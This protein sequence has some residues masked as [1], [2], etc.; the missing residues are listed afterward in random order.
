MKYS[1]NN[2]ETADKTKGAAIGNILAIVNCIGLLGQVNDFSDW[3]SKVHHLELNKELFEGY[4][5]TFDVLFGRLFDEI[6]RNSSL[7]LKED[8]WLSRALFAGIPISKVPNTS[9]KTVLLRNIHYLA[10]NVLLAR[11]WEDL[12]RCVSVFREKVLSHFGGLSEIAVASS[13][14]LVKNVEEAL[15]CAAIF[16]TYIF[17]ND[18]RRGRPH[19]LPL[20]WYDKETPLFWESRREGQVYFKRMFKGYKYALQ[21]IWYRLLEDDYNGSVLVSLSEAQNW[22]ELDQFFDK[23]RESVITPLETKTKAQFGFDSMLLIHLPV[24]DILGGLI[25]SGPPEKRLTK[26]DSIDRFF[27]WYE[28]ELIDASDY[29]FNG[30]ASFVP[31]LIGSIQMRQELKSNDKINVIRLV[32]PPKDTSDRHDFSYGI[33][34]SVGSTTGLSDYSG[35]LLFYDCCSDKGSTSPGYEFV[36]RWLN[37]YIK[38]GS[39]DVQQIIVGKKQFLK[40]MKH[41][42]IS[43][44]KQEMFRLERLTKSKNG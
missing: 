16:E 41:R 9:E 21:F 24:K 27:F 23:I 26:K 22:T 37:R 14:Y 44:T 35:W 29:G 8:M 18:T 13:T 40:L 1:N 12:I 25:Q 28:I 20:S 5:F 10:N 32:H 3:V 17:L 34:I 19:G 7:D 30:V 42:L 39:I 33:L 43:V 2:S 38:E 36:E 4:K 15:K 31:V 11:D 6:G